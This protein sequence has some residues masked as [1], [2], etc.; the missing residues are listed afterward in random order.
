MSAKAN[1][2]LIEDHQD[3]AEML[4]DYLER[5]GYAMDYAPTASPGCIWPSPATIRR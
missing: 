1:V 4:Y 2:L 5:Q 3:I